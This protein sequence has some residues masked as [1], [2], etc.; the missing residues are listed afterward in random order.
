MSSRNSASCFGIWS[1]T[2]K[3]LIRENG[4]YVAVEVQRGGLNGQPVATARMRRDGK[5]IP[6]HNLN[7]GNV[8][9]RSQAR[10]TR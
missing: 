3:T 1:V 9:H 8:A 10:A 6:V 4:L 2:V 7:Y 5:I